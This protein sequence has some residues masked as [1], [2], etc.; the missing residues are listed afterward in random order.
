MLSIIFTYGCIC[1]TSCYWCG[2]IR[3]YCWYSIGSPSYRETVLSVLQNAFL[4][5][6]ILWVSFPGHSGGGA[7]KA[8]R[9]IAT[10]SLEFKS[11]LSF[12]CGSS[13]TKLSNFRQ[14]AQSRNERECKQTLKNTH[15]GYNDIITN[16][17]STNQHFSL[18]FS[19]QIFKFQR[20]SCKLSF[21][22]PLCRQST[23]ES[24]PQANAI[25]SPELPCVDFVFQSLTT[26][27]DFSCNGIKLRWW[28]LPATHSFV[29][30]F[31]KS[32]RWFLTWRL[33]LFLSAKVE[34]DVRI[35]MII[36]PQLLE[37]FR[38]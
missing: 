14:S 21:L 13:S 30:L 15:Q 36:L 25:P 29:N 11:H 10:T 18:T 5:K 20:Y 32:F 31:L 6:T 28:C 7:G 17:T 12:P 35:W 37:T 24:M 1:H 23:P 33:S 9:A 3:S 22:F 8:R 27:S 16:V 34:T 2:Q 38:F 19:M 4:C 26:C